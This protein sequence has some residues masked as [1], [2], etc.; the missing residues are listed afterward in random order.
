[1]ADGYFGWPGALPGGSAVLAT[2]SNDAAT[3]SD[4]LTIARIDL[5]TGAVTS[6][7]DGGTYARWIP[8]GYLAFVRGNSLVATTYD[9]STNALGEMR[10]A[11][12]EDLFMDPAASSGCYAVSPAGVLVPWVLT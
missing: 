10:V 2:T 12:A 9:P 4:G 5:E 3:R 7:I 11:V 6:L 1:M 8:G